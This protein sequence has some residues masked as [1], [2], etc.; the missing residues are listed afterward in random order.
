MLPNNTKNFHHVSENDEIWVDGCAINTGNCAGKWLLAFLNFNKRKWSGKHYQ[1]S[2]NLC[3]LLKKE[4]VWIGSVKGNL[5]HRPTLI[6]IPIMSWSFICF[7]WKN[8]TGVGLEPT[9]FVSALTAHCA[10]NLRH[11]GWRSWH[12]LAG[13]Y[14]NTIEFLA[15]WYCLCWFWFVGWPK[16]VWHKLVDLYAIM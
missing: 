15:L 7:L 1:T 2:P 5:S 16:P 3:Q 13:F 14:S 4:W 10:N 9:T 8:L 11:R 6:T 12:N